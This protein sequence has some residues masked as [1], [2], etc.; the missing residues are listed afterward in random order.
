MVIIL[1]QYYNY[2]SN[3]KK[4]LIVDLSVYNVQNN[5]IIVKMVIKYLMMV[6]IVNCMKLNNVKMK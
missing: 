1:I 2:V 3:I 4:Q 6:L 5:V